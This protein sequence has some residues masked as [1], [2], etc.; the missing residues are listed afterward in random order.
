MGVNYPLGQNTGSQFA[1]M[2]AANLPRHNHTMP[3]NGTTAFIPTSATTAFDQREPQLAIN[4]YISNHGF[5][6]RRL[7]TDGKGDGGQPPARELSGG[8]EYIG[9]I[10]MFAGSVLPQGWLSCNGS[11]LSTTAEAALFSII[12]RL[13]DMYVPAIYI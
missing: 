11:S 12:G 3:Q 9:E 10:M 4:F 7:S 1:T 2:T 8:N 5:T 6:R 13:V